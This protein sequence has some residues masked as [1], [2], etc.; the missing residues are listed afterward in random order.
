MWLAQMVRLESHS[1]FELLLTTDALDKETGLGYAFRQE[2]RRGHQD[3]EEEEEN[4]ESQR[5]AQ[6][7]RN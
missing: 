7:R 3:N 5:I 1:F 4:Q 6:A 2:R